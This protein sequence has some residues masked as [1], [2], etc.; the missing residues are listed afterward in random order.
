MDQLIKFWTKH[1][2]RILFMLLSLILSGLL[3]YLDMKE[4][5][6]VIFIGLAMLCYNKARGTGDKDSK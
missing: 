6:R 5:A 2:D 4:E 1:C 3:Y